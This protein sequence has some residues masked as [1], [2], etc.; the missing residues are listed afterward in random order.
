MS[1]ADYKGSYWLKE[2]LIQLARKMGLPTHGYKPELSARIERRLRGLSDRTATKPPRSG[3]VRDSDK[4]LTLKTPVVNFNS[5]AKTRAFFKAQIGPR[6]HFTYHVNQYRLN[7]KGLTYGDLVKE[8]QAEKQRRD[9]SNYKAPIASHGK[10]NC[11]IRD[12]FADKKNKGKTLKD[13]AAA[14][15]KIRKSSGTLRYKQ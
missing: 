14:W 1:V 10:Y 7:N 3:G 12:Y 6:F 4:P 11:F 5:D 8:W 2:E 13:A 9:S 15:N